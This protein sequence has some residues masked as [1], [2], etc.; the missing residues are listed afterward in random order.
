[1]SPSPEPTRARDGGFTLVE[2]IVALGILLTVVVALLPQIVVGV[3]A[4]GTARLVTQAKGVA[5]G[6]LERMRN[7]PFHIAPEAGNFVDVLDFYYRNRSAPAL[8]PACTTGGRFNA[9]AAGWAGY[10]SATS[11]ARCSYEP[12]SGAF[13]RSIDVVAPTAGSVGFTVVTDVQ[14]L[15]GATPP[16]PVSPVAGYD[17]GVT[18]KDTPAS[19]QIGVTVSVLYADRGTVHPVSTYTQISAR[20]PSATRLRASADV[21]TLD[22]GSVTAD[23]VPLSLSAGVVHL[24]GSVTYAS[25]V[26]ANLASTTASLGTGEGAGGAARTTTAPPSASTTGSSAPAGEL[27]AAGCSYAC[28]G[29]SQVGPLSVSASNGLPLAG[30]ALAPA[31]SLVTSNEH[32][33][34]SFGN[35]SAAT[36]YRTGLK[37]TPPLLRLD[38]LGAPAPSA[39][40]GCAVGASGTPAYVAGSG[41]LRTTPATDPVSPLTVEAC[42]VARASAVEVLPTEFAPD[43]IVRLELTRASARCQVTGSAHTPGTSLDYQAVVKYWDGSAY[44]TAATVVPGQTADPLDSLPLTTA[45]GGGRTLGDYIASWSSLTAG[46]IDRTSAVGTARVKLP[47]VVT[48]TTQPLRPDANAADGLDA[49]SVMSVALGA[50]SCSAEDAR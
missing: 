9:P 38:P 21:T 44:V 48:L 1:M 50:L 12:S 19:S 39:L 10:V 37:L 47:G 32:A 36:A 34:I 11:A 28:W 16:A 4:T 8:A 25:T 6:Q 46:K 20:L 15:S 26:A 31:Q 17:T 42:A 13:F 41:Y 14:F 27:P 5:Q 2:I 22:V 33:A 3:R 35:S 45:V 23:A 40:S 43:G 24:S 18:G 49:T 30:S 7:L 29:A